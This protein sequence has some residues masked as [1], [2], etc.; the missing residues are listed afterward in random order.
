[1]SRAGRQRTVEL[2]RRL[3]LVSAASPSGSWILQHGSH[4]DK[5]DAALAAVGKKL[6][7]AARGN[8]RTRYSPQTAGKDKEATV[9]ACGILLTKCG[10]LTEV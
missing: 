4:M 10:L 2:S 6:C 3:G 8:V 7:V 1:M 9:E 5:M